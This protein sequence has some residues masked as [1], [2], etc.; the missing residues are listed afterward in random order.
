MK[1]RALS[2]AVVRELR[3]CARRNPYRRTAEWRHWHRLEVER[4][5]DSVAAEWTGPSIDDVTF[6][7]SK[8]ELK[9]ELIAVLF[10]GRDEALAVPTDSVRKV[11]TRQS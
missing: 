7:Y 5:D 4:D 10:D 1:I 3:T 2:F 8:L 6:V 9:G 11:S